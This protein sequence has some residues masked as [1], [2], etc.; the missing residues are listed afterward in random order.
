MWA[1][2]CNGASYIVGDISQIPEN[3]AEWVDV[4]PQIERE[5]YYSYGN[6]NAA[7]L[8]LLGRI[9]LRKEL[10]AAHSLPFDVEIKTDSNGKPCLQHELPHFSISHSK[11]K[12]AVAIADFPVGIDIQKLV[13]KSRE[14]L[15]AMGR[16]VF[17]PQEM[18]MLQ[19]AGNPQECFT[20][21]WV[22]KESY[23]KM[24][25][26]GLANSADIDISAIIN[27]TQPQSQL[28]FQPQSQP[29]CYYHTCLPDNYFLSVIA[30]VA[31]NY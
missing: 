26:T 22:A 7:D 16:K 9:L 19:D 12:V 24:L 4:L 2:I 14:T 10:L 8:F 11:E 30:K 25:G 21:L 1:K 28:Q 23:V 6:R 20:K 18:A 3:R 29:I 13:A 27:S 17:S 5:R 15:L 31:K